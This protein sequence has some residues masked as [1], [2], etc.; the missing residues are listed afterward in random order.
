MVFEGSEVFLFP[1]TI[2]LLHHCDSLKTRDSYQPHVKESKRV[3][4]SGFCISASL[5]MELGFRIPM[6]SAIP[7]SLS[8][9]M[10]SKT[11]D[12]RFHQ[13]KF[14]N[15]GFQ[16]QTFLGFRNPDSLTWSK[17]YVHYRGPRGLTLGSR[18][19]FFLIDTN[20]SRRSRVNKARSAERRQ[21][22]PKET[23]VRLGS[24]IKP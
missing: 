3:S 22:V 1:I 21:R 5:S 17:S 23:K 6:V 19:N 18:G 4:D 9:I 7:V 20:V 8:C 2:F 24:I 15:S 12:S 10:D 14:P 16:K 11:Q 13:I